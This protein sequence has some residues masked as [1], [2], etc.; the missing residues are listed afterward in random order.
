M[1]D[2]RVFDAINLF[3]YSPIG[4]GTAA[5]GGDAAYR[6][7][8]RRLARDILAELW[9]LWADDEIEW[10]DLG[11]DTVGDSRPVG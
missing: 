2:D 10:V 3:K 1:P 5:I 9:A 8:Y 4:M 11:P 7:K 6:A